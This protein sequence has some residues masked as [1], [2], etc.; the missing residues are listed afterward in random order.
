M[1][2]WHYSDYVGAG[3]PDLTAGDT[4]IGIPD[5][6]YMIYPLPMDNCDAPPCKIINV[7][8][9]VEPD[10]VEIGQ[11]GCQMPFIWA[12]QHGDNVFPS[13]LRLLDTSLSSPEVAAYSLGNLTLPSRTSVDHTNN[14]CYVSSSMSPGV[15]VAKVLLHPANIS[16]ID[17]DKTSR[18][19][20]AGVLELVNYPD[21][22]LSWKLYFN[23]NGNYIETRKNSLSPDYVS[24][25]TIQ[26]RDPLTN[27][28]FNS[29]WLESIKGICVDPNDGGLWVSMYFCRDIYKSK[30]YK[31]DRNGNKILGPI[32]SN[33]HMYHMF[34]M[35]YYNDNLISPCPRAAVAEN[36]KDN[37]LP[38]N[39][40]DM[41]KNEHV[42]GLMVYDIKKERWYNYLPNDGSEIVYLYNT[43]VHSN[44][45]YGTVVGG[46]NTGKI[47]RRNM[48]EKNHSFIGDCGGI[49]SFIR[50]LCYRQGNLYIAGSRPGARVYKVNLTNGRT[51][52]IHLPEIEGIREVT[53]VG[54]DAFNNVWCMGL[55]KGY[56]IIKP[57]DVVE[58]KEYKNNEGVH[59][60]HNDFVGRNV[61]SEEGRWLT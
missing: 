47:Y 48:S 14:C 42:S 6:Q 12:P 19:N 41:N 16:R 53:G 28:G 52:I 27:E 4:I 2:T 57:D 18:V 23:G 32:T 25:L 11:W 21:P 3:R 10:M 60:V 45:I 51:S 36:F 58:Y 20:M 50:G 7:D 8:M 49:T 37:K 1:A 61:F 59:Y 26:E 13:Q 5:G 22:C 29:N 34:G 17:K 44:T 31:F 30:L 39:Y 15:Q 40:P 38:S 54:V 43:I 33:D 56:H 46:P 9:C 24:G 35:S 55:Y